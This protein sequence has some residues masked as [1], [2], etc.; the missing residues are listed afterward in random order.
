MPSQELLEELVKLLKE[1]REEIKELR[2][3][4]AKLK[5]ERSTVTSKLEPESRQNIVQKLSK[6]PAIDFVLRDW[7]R[8]KRQQGA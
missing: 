5:S 2:A 6:S 1:Q 8:I 7:E 4:L 3:E